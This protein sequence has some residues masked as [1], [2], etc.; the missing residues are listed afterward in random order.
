MWVRDMNRNSNIGE[1]DD[2]DDDEEEDDDGDDDESDTAAPPNVTVETERDAQV[3]FT[4]HSD[5][6]TGCSAA[7]T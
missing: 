2:D 3:S 1:S 5:A 6:P 7:K 4:Q